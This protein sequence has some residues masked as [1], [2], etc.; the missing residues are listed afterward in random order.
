MLPCFYL[1]SFSLQFLFKIDSENTTVNVFIID[2]LLIRNDFPLKI[3][4][5]NARLVSFGAIL[6]RSIF[7][8][9]F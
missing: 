9:C 7:C 5:K 6:V 1:L 3:I 4:G 8:V 2:S